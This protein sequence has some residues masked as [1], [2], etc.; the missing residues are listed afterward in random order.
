MTEGIQ[1]E[2]YIVKD[3]RSEG[4]EGIEETPQLS[5]TEKADS[6]A[7]PVGE[8]NQQDIVSALADLKEE[9]GKQVRAFRK[10]I[11]NYAALSDRLETALHE[12]REAAVS[13]RRQDMASL[14]RAVQEETSRDIYQNLLDVRDSLVRGLE[15]TRHHLDN[16]SCLRKMAVG[17][18]LLASLIEGQELTLQRLDDC[19]S[20]TQIRELEA[21]G[22]PFDPHTMCA[23]AILETEALSEGTVVEIL[24]PGY[25]IRGEVLR[26]A[27]VRVARPPQSS[28]KETI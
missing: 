23:A 19:L 2:G 27:E 8:M 10:F 12:M 22:K 14:I 15:K 25:T 24:R 21:K 4:S 11:E 16:M 9:T 20:H 1:K 18:P 3:S 5:D 28:T 13:L 6:I 17:A 26:Y 7:P